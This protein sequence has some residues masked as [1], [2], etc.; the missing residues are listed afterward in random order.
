LGGALALAP[1]PA[2]PAA[3][4]ADGPALPTTRHGSPERAG[5]LPSHL[6]QLVFGA[7]AFLGPSLK[8]PWY[9]GAV[10]LAGR[11]AT[12]ALHQPI[13]RAVRYQAYDEKTDT[14][15]E[16]PADQQIPMARD[17]VFDLASVSKPFTSVLAVQL[18]ER[19][20][21]QRAGTVAS[22]VPE[23]AAAGKQD[24]CWRRARTAARAGSPCPSP[25]HATASRPRSIRRVR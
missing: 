10:L 11:G 2:G 1:L 7:E 25:P 12:V 23:F 20:A 3:R 13:G 16:F 18:M 19:G 4:A 15:V 6:R 22:Y 17:T 9:A 8:H 24:M 5:L 14:S 21:L